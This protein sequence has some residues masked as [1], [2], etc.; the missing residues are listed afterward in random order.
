MDYKSDKKASLILANGTVIEGK[1]IGA[2]G[3][4]IGEVVFSTSMT[5][6]QE[7]LSDLSYH[8]Q[9]LTQTFPLVGNYGVNK[10][11]NEAVKTSINGYIVREI[12]D[13]PSN[14]RSDGKLNDYLLSN[15]IIGICDIDTRHLTRLLKENG[16][17][18]GMITTE[19]YDLNKVLEEIKSFEIKKAVEAVSVKEILSYTAEKPLYN[20]VVIDYGHKKSLESELLNRN[21]N[22]TIYPYNVS[23]S[24]IISKNPDG[25]VLTSG[26]GNPDENSECIETIK[27]LLE[28][29]TPILGIGLGHQMIA[30]AHGCTNIKMINGHRGGNQPVV[31]LKTGKTYITS[32]NHGYTVEAESVTSDIGIITHINANDKT[33]E[34]ILYANMPVFSVQFNPQT[35]GGANDTAY[36][37][38]EFIKMIENNK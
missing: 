24:E 11:D 8:G 14:F 5:A 3:T 26:P 25:I 4:T 30:K 36:I 10:D 15:N 16:D 21:C 35:L 23:A 31:N 28:K 7:A 9:I 37:F 32:Q 27:A 2:V 1:A 12:C 19:D 18:N 33:C 34:G 13:A 22:L 20:I 38:E 29:K 6:Y 17:M